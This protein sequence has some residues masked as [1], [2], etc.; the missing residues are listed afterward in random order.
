[1]VVRNKSTSTIVSG[2][3]GSS[4][5][6]TSA[7]ASSGPGTSGTNSTSTLVNH[8][9]CQH[10]NSYPSSK[11][12]LRTASSSSVVG[13][14]LHHNHNHHH[15]YRKS[16]GGSSNV[17]LLDD[18]RPSTSLG[19]SRCRRTVVITNHRTNIDMDV[20]DENSDDSEQSSEETNSSSTPTNNNANMNT[21]SAT[22]NNNGTASVVMSSPPSTT[23]KAS[24]I[25]TTT[26]RPKQHRQ[27]QFHSVHKQNLYIVSF[28]IIFLFN[29]LRTLIFQLFCV[30][31][32]L[33]GAS[34]KFV[35]I[36]RRRREGNI[37]IVVGSSSNSG[38]EQL[39]EQKIPTTQLSVVQ[40]N[41]TVQQK[42]ESSIL[43]LS[44]L[45][46]QRPQVAEMYNKSSNTSNISTHGL[47]PGPGDPLLAKQK[48]HHRR[49]FEYISKALKIDEE[50]EGK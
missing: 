43:P 49:A 18:A 46:V 14:H 8:N 7:N 17:A 48:H 5:V 11:S 22:N 26:R 10:N 12:P 15:A 40:P 1:M 4:S 39:C 9:A 27:P 25:T 19:L 47:S 36:P 20:N 21:N 34:T 6:T 23:M 31:R 30:F 29:I 45:P 44:V 33:Y 24:T 28:P 37:E 42:V 2:V 3:I 13:Y 16:S 50:N 32:Y 35:Y 38:K 41:P